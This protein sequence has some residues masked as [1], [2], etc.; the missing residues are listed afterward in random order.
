MEWVGLLIGTNSAYENETDEKH[1][2]DYDGNHD[3]DVYVSDDKGFDMLIMITMYVRVYCLIRWI[4]WW[5]SWWSL[6]LF[7]GFK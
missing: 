4:L 5:W 3:V 2:K 1:Q 6:Y 7:W